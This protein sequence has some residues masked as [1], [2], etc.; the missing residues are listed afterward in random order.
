MSTRRYDA[1]LIDFYGTISSGDREAVEQACLEVVQVCDLPIESGELAIAWGE[2]FFSMI[3]RSN[4]DG[5]R[6]LYECEIESLRETLAG[7]DR[8]ADP[9]PLVRTLEDYWADPPIYADALEFLRHVD[10]PICCVSNA[11]TEP[12]LAAL[13]RRGLRFSAVVTSEAARCYKPQPAIFEHALANLGATPDRVVH[14]GDSLHSDI[15]GAQSLGIDTIWVRRPRRIHDVG[16]STPTQTVSSLTE[17]L[18]HL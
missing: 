3:D 11:D 10:R 7:F 18:A 1:I 17:A 8:D 14:I 16:E 9:L 12:L 4:H 6:T 5:F 2:R 15:A 13:D